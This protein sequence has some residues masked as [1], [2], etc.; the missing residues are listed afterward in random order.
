MAIQCSNQEQLHRIIEIQLTL[1]QAV[2][3]I[4][5]FTLLVVKTL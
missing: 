4:D 2:L 1:A 3:D 5:Q